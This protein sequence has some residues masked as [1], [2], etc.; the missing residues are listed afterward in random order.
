MHTNILKIKGE[1]R[2]RIDL[3]V[4]LHVNVIVE[5][6]QVEWFASNFILLHLPSFPFQITWKINSK[7]KMLQEC[8]KNIIYNL[9]FTNPSLSSSK[10]KVMNIEVKRFPNITIIQRERGFVFKK[11]FE[12]QLKLWQRIVLKIFWMLHFESYIYECFEVYK[13]DT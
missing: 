3:H 6:L 4:V 1:W 8:E 5:G 9:I 2:Q 10:S 11:L 7:E 12:R 13:W